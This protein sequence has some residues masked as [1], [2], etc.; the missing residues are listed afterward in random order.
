VR[1]ALRPQV[2][3]EREQVYRGQRP[4]VSRYDTATVERV[5]PYILDAESKPPSEDDS[6]QESGF[7]KA[8]MDPSR[9]QQW[10]V[11]RADV[12]EA[13]RHLPGQDKRVL[14]ARYVEGYT[15][16]LIAHLFDI[17]RTTVY[18]RGQEALDR[19]IES[20][21][22]DRPEQGP[23]RRVLSNAQARAVT[24]QQYLG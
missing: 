9:Y 14:F 6:D 7:Q 5:L 23:K 1:R 10:T 17:P 22:G 2:E 15:W 21:N 3:E 8:V 18:R 24:D 13:L 11:L 20:L 12:S 19:L 16:D 4:Y